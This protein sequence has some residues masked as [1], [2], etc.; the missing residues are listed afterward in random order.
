[1]PNAAKGKAN[2]PE[3]ASLLQC[4]W[5]LIQRN[6][7]GFTLHKWNSRQRQALHACLVKIWSALFSIPIPKS[8]KFISSK[9]ILIP[10]TTHL[11]PVPVFFN[12]TKSFA[13]FFPEIFV[14]ICVSVLQNNWQRSE[15]LENIYSAN[16]HSNTLL[17]TAKHNI[18]KKTTWYRIQT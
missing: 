11:S 12:V 2:F 18:N 9:E 6:S 14:G 4:I 16:P 7:T 15:P 3:K 8:S 13:L 1:M 10:S 17:R 5:N